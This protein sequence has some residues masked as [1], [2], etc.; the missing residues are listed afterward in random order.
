MDCST[1]K[2]EPDVSKMVLVNIFWLLFWDTFLVLLLCILWRGNVDAC[3][4]F[5]HGLIEKTTQKS[6][7]V[8]VLSPRADV[9]FSWVCVALVPILKHNLAQM[10]CSFKLGSSALNMHKNK[11]LLSSNIKDCGC[12]TL[13]TDAEGIVSKRNPARSHQSYF[14]KIHLNTP[15]LQEQEF[16]FVEHVHIAF[17]CWS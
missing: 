6:V 14:R 17:F 3:M 12:K 8:I 1:Q 7:L 9:S 10:H 4:K 5:C 2:A 13:E 15:M 16:G 11:H